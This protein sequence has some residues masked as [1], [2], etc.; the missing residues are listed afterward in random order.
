[1][2]EEHPYPG[3]ERRRC[4]CKYLLILLNDPTADHA[5]RSS[6]GSSLHSSAV[7]ASIS[8]VRNRERQSPSLRYALSCFRLLVYIIHVLYIPFIRLSMF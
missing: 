5:I 4:Y 3:F 6:F 2:V 7:L 1:M 8:A